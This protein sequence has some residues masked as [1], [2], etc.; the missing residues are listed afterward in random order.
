MAASTCDGDGVVKSPIF[1]VAAF[2]E[3]LLLWSYLVH[4]EPVQGARPFTGPA[5]VR[6]VCFAPLA[7]KIKMPLN[8][9]MIGW[10]GI[11]DCSLDHCLR[12]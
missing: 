5:I 9:L 6:Q 2:R 10:S 8:E 11:M 4:P 3:A 12:R 1:G 7:M